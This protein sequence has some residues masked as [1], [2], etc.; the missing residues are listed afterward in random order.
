M[1]RRVGDSNGSIKTIMQPWIVAKSIYLR[2]NLSAEKVFYRPVEEEFVNK[3]AYLSI[4]KVSFKTEA[5]L[6]IAVAVTCNFCTERRYNFKDKRVETYKVPLTVFQLKS[7]PPNVLQV[8][9]VTPIWFPITT[10]T[11]RLEFS[12][13]NMET[14]EE[15]KDNCVMMISVFFK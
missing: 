11:E 13:E 5:R 14:G 1:A 12:F 4:V 15:V 2:A 7:S 3:L 10:L 6:N 8:F 9:C